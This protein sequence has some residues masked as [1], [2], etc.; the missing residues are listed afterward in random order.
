MIITIFTFYVCIKTESTFAWM[1]VTFFVFLSFIIVSLSPRLSRWVS[2]QTRQPP[3]HC[4]WQPTSSSSQALQVCPPSPTNWG[5]WFWWPLR[6]VLHN[7]HIEGPLSLVLGM[8]SCCLRS[9][10]AKLFNLINGIQ[11]EPCTSDILNSAFND[12]LILYCSSLVSR[13]SLLVI[14]SCPFHLVMSCVAQERGTGEGD[15]QTHMHVTLL[16]K[17]LTHCGTIA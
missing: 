7:V 13:R 9:Y 2:V 12:P 4:R 5:A 8:R 17:C 14:F 11:C 15:S 10:F 1:E 6:V 3:N 16:A